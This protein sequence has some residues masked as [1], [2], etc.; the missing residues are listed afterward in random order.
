MTPNGAQCDPMHGGC[1]ALSDL[2]GELQNNK[3]SKDYVDVKMKEFEKKLDNMKT[4][5]VSTC[6]S[7]LA[8]IILTIL[9]FALSL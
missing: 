4:W 5:L 3:A 8:G 1:K 2:R 7:V 6:V 9:R